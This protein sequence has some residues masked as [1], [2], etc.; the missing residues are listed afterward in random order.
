MRRRS[1]SPQAT[2]STA[3]FLVSSTSRAASAM[4]MDREGV[5]L[6]PA[7]PQAAW[8]SFLRVGGLSYTIKVVIAAVRSLMKGR[9][10]LSLA[11]ARKILFD[12]SRL[13]FA[14]FIGSSAGHPSAIY[15]LAQHTCAKHGTGEMFCDACIRPQAPTICSS[16]PAR[17][18]V[19]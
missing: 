7:T 12:D 1:W 18:A 8:V 14:F 2:K 15:A 10:A 3:R 9:N 16:G 5:E 4:R 19:T 17:A 11:V 13:R 6:T